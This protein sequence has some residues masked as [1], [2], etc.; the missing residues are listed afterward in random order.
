MMLDFYQKIIVARSAGRLSSP[1]SQRDRVVPAGV[2][3]SI[4]HA[5]FARTSRWRSGWRTP[6][7][8][9]VDQHIGTGE[10]LLRNISKKETV[11]TPA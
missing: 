9:L 5:R 7:R 2:P 8:G 3:R 6:R 11:I 10:D 4:P 1:E